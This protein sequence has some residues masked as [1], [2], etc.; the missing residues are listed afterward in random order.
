MSE[1]ARSGKASDVEPPK[2]HLG[3][4][5]ARA[6]LAPLR[7]DLA[8]LERRTARH[9]TRLKLRPEDQERMATALQAVR[10]ASATIETLWASTEREQP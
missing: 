4:Q 6:L 2:L 3:E 9:V 10:Q 5:G 7:A 8:V 1:A